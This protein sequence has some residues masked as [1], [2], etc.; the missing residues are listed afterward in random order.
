IPNGSDFPVEKINPLYGFYAAVVRKDLKGFPDGGFQTENALSREEALKAMTIWAAKSGF[1]ETRFG[2][3]EPG[4]FADF[5]ILEE[6]LMSMDIDKVPG[7]KVI[8]TYIQ[9]EKVFS[10]E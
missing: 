7:I 10:R 8:S 1:E 4:K 6:D 5:I 9:G 2:S 3:I